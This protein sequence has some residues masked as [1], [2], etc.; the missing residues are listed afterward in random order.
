MKLINCSKRERGIPY[1]EETKRL[2]PGEEM[3]IDIVQYDHLLS[4]PMAQA[5]LQ[6]GLIKIERGDAAEPEPAAHSDE[7]DH[8]PLPEGL[9]G[10]GTEIHDH[11]GGWF[12][13]YHEGM[14]CTDVKIREEQ[15]KAIAAEYEE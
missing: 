3:P 9:T 8:D 14:P 15:A 12:S 10:Q 1:P 11:G 6:Q 4:H 13:V 7:R 5:W 2:G